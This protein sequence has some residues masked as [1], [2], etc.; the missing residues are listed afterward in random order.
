[1]SKLTPALLG[2]L[3]FAFALTA[4]FLVPIAL[5]F[6]PR[7]AKRLAWSWYDTPDEPDLYDLDIPTVRALH[8]RWGRFI[9]AW[10]WFGWRNRAHGFDS[11]FSEIATAHWPEGEGTYQAGE[12]F[13]TRRRHGDFVLVFGWQVYASQKYATGLEFRPQLAIKRRPA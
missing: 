8:E 9:T 13:I 3:C 12:F 1:M 10:Y 2:L 4:P 7:D 6:T 5:L 11:L